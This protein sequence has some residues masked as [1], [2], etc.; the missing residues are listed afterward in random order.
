MRIMISIEHAINAFVTATLP[1][2]TLGGDRQQCDKGDFDICGADITD[3][4]APTE[5]VIAFYDSD[6]QVPA[7]YKD[8]VAGQDNYLDDRDLFAADILEANV[9]MKNRFFW[10]QIF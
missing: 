5:V 6:Q 9:D 1:V 8:T 2:A 7:V 4:D 10:K 3:P